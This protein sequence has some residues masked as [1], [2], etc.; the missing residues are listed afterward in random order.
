MSNGLLYLPQGAA[1]VL[2][3]TADEINAINGLQEYLMNRNKVVFV[4]RN[5]NS[6]I[7]Y[8]RFLMYLLFRFTY[9]LLLGKEKNIKIIR[10]YVD[11]IRGVIDSKYPFI[12]IEND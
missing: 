7:K 4:K 10:Y 3:A 8:I 2:K 9:R 6:K 1:L 5:I 12:V 11:G